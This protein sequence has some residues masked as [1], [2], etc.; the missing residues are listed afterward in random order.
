MGRK[1]PPRGTSPKALARSRA[2]HTGSPSA[3]PEHGSSGRARAL[4]SAPVSGPA[5]EP[6]WA[7]Y[8]GIP[9][10]AATA[11]QSEMPWDGWS[12]AGSA[13][14]SEPLT[15]LHSAQ[16][17]GWGSGAG[18]AS[19]MEGGSAQGSEAGS[20]GPLVGGPVRTCIR[21]RR[22]TR[23]GQQRHAR[24]PAPP[25]RPLSRA[26]EQRARLPV[27][28]PGRARRPCPRRLCPRRPGRRWPDPIA[29][30]GRRRPPRP[31][32]GSRPE[33]GARL[34]RPLPHPRP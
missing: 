24:A 30:R 28:S 33:H 29:A 17:M 15:G 14:A 13:G 19:G 7:V 23:A 34:P 16:A 20:V 12:A 9:W 5:W 4:H 3:G 6:L 11:G 8:W 27:R 25:Q 21:W 2:T 10:V 18:W 22:L 31:S 1:A 32:G 26:L